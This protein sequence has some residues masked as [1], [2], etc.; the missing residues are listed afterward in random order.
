MFLYFLQYNV[1]L[2]FYIKAQIIIISVFLFDVKC[3]T[4]FLT[5]RKYLLETRF[6]SFSIYITLLLHNY[7]QNQCMHC[8]NF[9]QVFIMILLFIQINSINMRQ[10][11]IQ[12]FQ[13]QQFFKSLI[14]FKVNLYIIF[15][16]NNFI[17]AFI[18]QFNLCLSRKI[19]T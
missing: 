14:F 6:F 13:N 5:S 9:C 15:N 2:W 11:E 16:V 7:Y 17:K 1:Y 18:Q 10:M 8:S 4:T 12:F 19:I 3:L